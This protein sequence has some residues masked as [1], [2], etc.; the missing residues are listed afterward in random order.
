MEPFISESIWLETFNN[1][2]TRNG[3]TSDG[4][5]LWNPKMDA[6]DKVI[7]ALKYFIEQ[8]A[9]GSYKQTVRLKQAIT[10][11]PGPRGEK[12]EIDDEIAGFYG[13][14]QIKLDPL[15][16]MDFKLNEYLQGE[17]NTRKL[18]SV[19]LTKGGKINSND[20]IEDFFYANRKK[21]ELMADLKQG[22]EFAKILNVR[23]KDLEKV[24]DDRKKGSLYDTLQDNR[25]KPFE[26]TEKQERVVQEQYEN[27]IRDFDGIVYNRPLDR[28]TQRTLDRMIKDM[29]RVRLTDDFN[30]RMKLEN[31]LIQQDRSELPTQQPANVQPLPPQPQPN[32]AIVSKPPIDPNLQGGLTATETGLL[33]DAEKAIRLRQQGLA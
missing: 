12:Y 30:D 8:T 5:R 7:E 32:P 11:E 28:T 26:F 20:V 4:R 24:Y 29:S 19:P 18:Y 31:Y 21:F 9:P 2:V 15:K 33:S 13:L 1:L 22:N 10:G 3:V 17:A 25:F 27:I 23:K 14:R 16:K 6:P